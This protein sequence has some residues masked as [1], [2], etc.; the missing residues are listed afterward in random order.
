M[1][2]AHSR[3]DVFSRIGENLY[4]YMSSEVYYARYWNKGKLIHHSLNTTDREFA[5][6]QLNEELAK[7]NKVDA[8]RGKN[9]AGRIVVEI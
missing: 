6:R 2:T 1:K 4:R 5:K 7:I 3:T 9:D 8:A